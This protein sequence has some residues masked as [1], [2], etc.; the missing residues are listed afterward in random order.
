MA[1]HFFDKATGAL[2]FT[3]IDKKPA[4]LGGLLASV[5]VKSEAL[6][7]FLKN[8]ARNLE[9]ILLEGVVNV[10]KAIDEH[11]VGSLS[12]YASRPTWAAYAIKNEGDDDMPVSAL[13]DDHRSIADLKSWM[14]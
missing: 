9:D 3:D 4:D 2:K 11:N 14:K 13:A 10:N 5:K 7:D 1:V 8:A 6:P 12:L